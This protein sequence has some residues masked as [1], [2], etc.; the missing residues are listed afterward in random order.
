MFASAE[1]AGHYLK[2]SR[3]YLEGRLQPVLYDNKRREDT[4]EVV[5]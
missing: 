3:I 4:H 2:K 5:S 1:I